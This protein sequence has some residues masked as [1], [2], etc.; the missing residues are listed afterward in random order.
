MRIFNVILSIVGIIICF[1][2]LIN[3]LGYRSNIANEITGDQIKKI[4]NGMSLDEVI[5]ILGNPYE[6]DILAGQ[7][8]LSCKNP[9][10]LKM[11][12]NK[13]SNIIHVLDSFFNDTSYCCDTYQEIQKGIYKQHVRLT[14]TKPVRFSKYYPMLRLY[15]D[16]N[17]HVRN[18]VAK[19]CDFIDCICIYSL[20]WKLDEMTLEERPGEID[21]FIDEKLFD[22]CFPRK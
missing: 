13:N 2:L 3:I 12:V 5:S 6:I 9:N 15:L 10:L 1:V 11:D 17:Y 21:L 18:L 8:D 7:H 14:Y 4:E 22:K 16:S 19:R 20:S